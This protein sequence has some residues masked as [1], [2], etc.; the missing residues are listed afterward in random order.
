MK[1]IQKR[2]YEGQNIYSHKKCIRI[3]MDLEGYCEIP[4]KEIPNF[5]FNLVKLIPELKTHRC[6]IDEEGG[7]VKRLEEGTYLAHICEH[8][9]IAIQNNLGI[10]VSYGKAREIE[11]DMYYIIVEYE[12]KNTVNEVAKLAVDLMNCL[13]K[14]IP[15]NFNGR[16]DIIKAILQNE[17]MGCTTKAIC[18]AAKEYNLPIMQLGDSNIY[19]IGYGK[20]SRIIE[21]SIGSKTKCVGVDIS[22]DKLLTKQLLKNQNIPVAD[23]SKVFNVIGLLQDAE[24]IGYPVVLK[25]QCGNKGQGVILNIKNQKQLINTYINLRKNQK[26]IIIEKYFEGNDYR[27]CLVNYKV[28]AV[29][30][31]LAPFVI[32]NGMYN[33]RRLIDILNEDPLRGED[34]EKALTKVKVD[35]ELTSC[36]SKRNLDLDYIPKE[37]EKVLLRENANLSTGGMAIDCTE[38]ICQENIECCIN[39]A[40]TLGL[41]ICGIDICTKDISIPLK[42]SNGIIMEVNA[43]PGIRMHHYPW[44]GKKRNI[45]KA[46]LEMLY[47]EKP[48]NIPIVSI[49]GTNGKT[50]TTRLISH[51]L[52]K[53][54]NCVGMTCTDGIYLNDKCIHKGDDSGFD[55]AKTI[56]MN[57]EVD[58]AVLETARGGLV[59][60]GLAYNLADVGII[61]NVTN[62]H[63][64][65]D[66]INSIEELSFTKALVGEAVKK[67]GV[68]VI[69]ADDKYSK[70]I[71]N[72]FEAE[73]IYFSK[74]KDNPLIQEN[75]SNGKTAVFIEDNKI[76]VVNDNRKYEIVSIKEL[77]IS[78]AGKLE[79]NI[80][81]AMAACAGLVGLNID[82]CMISKGLMDFKLNSDNNRGRFNMYDYGGRKVILDYAHN[83]EGYK[84]V[85]SSLKKMKNGNNLIGVIGIPG[86][87]KDDI[88]YAIGEICAKNLDKIIIKEDKDKRGRKSGD[89]AAILEKAILK[90]NKNTNLKICLDEV[91][92]LKYA[93]EISEKDDIIIVFY[94]KLDSLLEIVKEEPKEPINKMD[95]LEEKCKTV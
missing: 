68:V 29:A 57:N 63:L 41:D 61:T 45:G 92:A 31:R 32:G 87:R 40:K 49:T 74:F 25:P 12:Y 35:S 15:I 48:K 7:F 20:M 93:I 19:Q 53:M 10:D 54:G 51:V 2:I 42:E 84:S 86:D 24:K 27:V 28:E 69:N 73:K 94:E 1:I 47:D 34:H 80:E 30:L 75:I 91:E 52:K 55:S 59:R 46:I 3:D 17:Q 89:V 37:G 39:A 33:L 22:C 65:L 78:Y 58:I 36:L 5:N 81:N 62:D 72:R 64:G 56:L 76:C 6:G 79:Y 13:I 18:D 23:G 71:I 77:P 60:R 95:A 88:G 14:Q 66:G 83:I 70:T 11:G 21:A 50:T 44:K 8:T 26:D 67:N 16:I 38:E 82:Y 85:M 9:M 43:A 4:S 90:T